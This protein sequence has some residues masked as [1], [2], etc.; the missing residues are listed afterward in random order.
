MRCSHKLCLQSLADSQ[1]KLSAQWH[2]FCVLLVAAASNCFVVSSNSR[3]KLPR[4]LSY[5]AL[6]ER[7][8]LLQLSVQSQ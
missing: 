7:Q 4:Q 8:S 6:L 3:G 2:A 5:K 1:C